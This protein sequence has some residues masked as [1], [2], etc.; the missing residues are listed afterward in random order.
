MVVRFKTSANVTSLDISLFLITLL[1]SMA[2]ALA[3][4]KLAIWC[5][6]GDYAKALLV[7]FGTALGAHVMLLM[8]GLMDKVPVED[9]R[10]TKLQWQIRPRPKR[11]R[12]RFG[13]YLLG[14]MLLLTP[15]SL[16]IGRLFGV[17]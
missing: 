4:A 17:N 14:T 12:I 5:M 2:F 11:K 16:P 15:N 1:M 13:Y 9:K 8:I 10:P 7:G 6:S 3:G